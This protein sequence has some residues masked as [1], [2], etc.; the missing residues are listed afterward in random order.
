[1]AMGRVHRV[2]SSASMRNLQQAATDAIRAENQRLRQELVDKE[3]RI[4]Q[5][6]AKFD[7]LMSEKKF[8]QAESV[9][10]LAMAM[11]PGNSEIANAGMNATMRRALDDGIYLRRERIRGVLAMLREVEYS[12][13]PPA[14]GP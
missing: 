8:T 7:S 10:D 13:L 3:K 5:W 11:A 9:A 2:E 12:H 6:M 14:D 4:S 1:G